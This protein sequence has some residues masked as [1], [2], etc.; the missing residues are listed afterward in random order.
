MAA[1]INIGSDHQ[2]SSQLLP[3][4]LNPP[5]DNL[6]GECG[7][8][9]PQISY[10]NVVNLVRK[11]VK[12]V[13]QRQKNIIVSGLEEVDGVDDGELFGHLCVEE[14]G[15][16]P[17]IQPSGTRRLGKAVGAGPR[18]LLVKLVSDSTAAELRGSAKRLRNSKNT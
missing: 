17:L 3:Q 15:I 5:T 9:A 10:A 4:Q 14:L 11:S 16:K 7:L 2:P 8:T 12:E 1:R 18:K 6:S 13:S